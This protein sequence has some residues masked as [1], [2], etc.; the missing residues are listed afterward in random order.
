MNA[1]REELFHL[2]LEQANYGRE[3]SE[4]DRTK[5]IFNR[6]DH[7][8]AFAVIVGGEVQRYF[9]NEGKLRTQQPEPLL[10]QFKDFAKRLTATGFLM[11][12]L[13]ASMLGP[14]AAGPFDGW[15]TLAFSM[16]DD[17]GHDS[18]FLGVFRAGYVFP[19]C[20]YF[21]DGTGTD[22]AASFVLDDRGSVVCHSDSKYAGLSF[23]DLPMF[24]AIRGAAGQAG[25]D[26]PGTLVRYGNPAGAAVTAAV[27]KIVP[28]DVLLVSEVVESELWGQ[29]LSSRKLVF[30]LAAIG[31]V[32]LGS[33]AALAAKT[34]FL[35]SKN[36]LNQGIVAAEIEAQTE[37]LK[38]T[39]LTMQSEQAFVAAF[40]K[41]A[42]ESAGEGELTRTF[43]DT[44]S[45]LT[46]SGAGAAMPAAWFAY[47]EKDGMIEGT[48]CSRAWNLEQV[49]AVRFSYVHEAG[50]FKKYDDFFARMSP[51]LG[52]SDLYL[53]P[54]FFGEM[55]LGVAVVGD[56]CKTQ[57]SGRIDV[58]PQ[59]CQIYAS[60]W[61]AHARSGDKNAT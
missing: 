21:S 13:E 50:P 34:D 47:H 20:Q 38:H 59:L 39:V 32:T 27:K 22:P 37:D 55:F 24:L 40:L 30:A 8:A 33:A 54:V 35:T 25:A 45:Q 5:T 14:T 41:G 44:I 11:Q 15:Y 28:G 31:L 42:V 17:S 3:F 10:L 43:L 51:A 61:I 6:R 46:D 26:S 23:K 52:T 1:L 60:A 49:S 56:F 9:V 4:K 48:A 58:L 36:R 2:Y 53:Q 18:I 7:L 29:A 57:A 19:F 12:R 16:K